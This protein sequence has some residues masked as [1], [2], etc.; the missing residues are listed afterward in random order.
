[1]WSFRLFVVLGIPVN[2]RVNAKIGHRTHPVA[3]T[4]QRP[5]CTERHLKHNFLTGKEKMI[6]ITDKPLKTSVSFEELDS[7][8]VTIHFGDDNPAVSSITLERTERIGGYIGYTIPTEF[9]KATVHLKP[10]YFTTSTAGSVIHDDIKAVE[11]A[12][13]LFELLD[14]QEPED[15]DIDALRAEWRAYKDS[16][17]PYSDA[18]ID[19][20][21][22]TRTELRFIR[23]F[24]AYI[25][26][27]LEIKTDLE[28]AIGAFSET[29]TPEL[30]KRFNRFVEALHLS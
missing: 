13:R 12:V 21:V 14:T 8:P 10:D 4:H 16:A 6:V 5:I 1:M 15:C 28:E 27:P 7:G 20:S 25:N 24:L 29:E 17:E 26:R 11:E 19:S 9:I 23:Y 22:Y 2:E 3:H 30:S 18:I